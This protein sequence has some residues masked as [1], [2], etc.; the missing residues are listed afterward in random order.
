MKHKISRNRKGA[1]QREHEM[2]PC[3]EAT[4]ATLS[5]RDIF[6]ADDSDIVVTS[7]RNRSRSVVGKGYV[8]EKHEVLV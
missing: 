3:T 1:L 2:Y 6:G 8:V 7:Y 5:A 4:R